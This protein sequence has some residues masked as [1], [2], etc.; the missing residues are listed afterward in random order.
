MPLQGQLH[1]MTY[2]PGQLFSVNTTTADNVPNLFAR[3]ER[4]V[5]VFHTPAGPMAVIL[6][7]AMIV[8]GIDTVWAGQVAPL[9]RVVK[10]VDYQLQ[11]ELIVLKKGDEMGRFKLGSTV[12]VLFGKAAVAWAPQLSAGSA[13]KMG[14]PLGT[15]VASNAG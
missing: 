7:G 5:C 2:V 12:I 14:Q 9:Q 8:A 15:L 13:V 6:V 4:A 3:N 11:P 10:T 1:S